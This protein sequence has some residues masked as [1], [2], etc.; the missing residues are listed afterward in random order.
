MT[1]ITFSTLEY[2]PLAPVTVEALPNSDYRSGSRRVNRVATLDG[3]SVFNDFGF[4]FSDTTFTIAFRPVSLDQY[5]AVKRLVETYPKIT[6]TVPS[7]V[8]LAAPESYE[9][10][11]EEMRVRL[12]VERKLS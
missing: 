4:T 6:V 9:H 5:E 7:G 12:L 11:S 3:G 10:S 1:A 2:D 8:Y